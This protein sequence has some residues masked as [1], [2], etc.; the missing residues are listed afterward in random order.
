MKLLMFKYFFPKL[1]KTFKIFDFS[2]KKGTPD[3]RDNSQSQ[4]KSSQ[5]H[6]FYFIFW[7]N[8]SKWLWFFH[9]WISSSPARIFSYWEPCI[10]VLVEFLI[11]IEEWL[12]FYFMLRFPGIEEW[13]LLIIC[14]DSLELKSKVSHR[15]VIKVTY[16]L[17]LK[18]LRRTYGFTV[19]DVCIDH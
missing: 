17:S 15:S 13:S 19:I 2:I 3:L 14:Y 18:T 16:P 1:L 8:K 4:V 10:R 12:F 7:K 9:L 6:D 11:G 5:S